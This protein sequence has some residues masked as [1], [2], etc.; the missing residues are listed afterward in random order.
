MLLY[1]TFGEVQQACL[2]EDRHNGNSLNVVVVMRH[3]E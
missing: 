2:V 3:L 1:Q